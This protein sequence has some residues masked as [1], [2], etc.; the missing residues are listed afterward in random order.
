VE[1]EPQGFPTEALRQHNTFGST[2]RHVRVEQG[3]RSG[4]VLGGHRKAVNGDDPGPFFFRRK[5]YCGNFDYLRLCRWRCS[6]HV[7]LGLRRNTFLA[8]ARPITLEVL[9]RA[10]P[11]LLAARTPHGSGPTA[12]CAW[13]INKWSGAHSV[14]G[15]VR[16]RES[17]KIW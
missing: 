11:C 15:N 2:L 3:H 17:M 6:N 5:Q 9:W 7:V 8:M 13:V 1:R 4:T 10:V 12:Q 16:Y 14:G